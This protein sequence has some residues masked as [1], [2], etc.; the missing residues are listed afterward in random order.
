MGAGQAASLAVAASPIFI[1]SWSGGHS[2]FAVT[3]A[4]TVGTGFDTV[5]VTVW[6][7][8]PLLLSVG[9][10]AFTFAVLLIEVLF[11]AL[12]LAV[13]TTVNAAVCPFAMLNLVQVMLSELPTAGVVQF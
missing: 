7:L 9:D 13:A 12:Q 4:L 3:V 2:V 6:E 11:G 8:L 5:R 1:R 10:R